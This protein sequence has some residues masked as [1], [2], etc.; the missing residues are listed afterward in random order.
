[1]LFMWRMLSAD[2]GRQSMKY[3]FKQNPKALFEKFSLVISD[4]G[5][6]AVI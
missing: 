2:L 6:V 1:M 3:E 4:I 5:Y